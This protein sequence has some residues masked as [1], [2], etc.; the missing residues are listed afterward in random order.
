MPHAAGM[1]V[2]QHF[3]KHLILERNLY[4]T[5]PEIDLLQEICA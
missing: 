2:T 5:D 1:L 4:L 3:Q